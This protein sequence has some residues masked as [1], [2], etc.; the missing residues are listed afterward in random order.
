MIRIASARHFAVATVGFVT[1]LSLTTP[2]GATVRAGTLEC[3][4]SG[5]VG[6]VFVEKQEMRCT[7]RPAS[8][9]APE[10]YVGKIV[11]VGIALG[12]TAG[13][14]MVWGVL[15]AEHDIARGALA[16]TYAG[17]SANASIGIGGGANVL[18]GGTGRAF[19]LQPLSLEG[20]LGL[21]V[22]GGVTTVTLRPAP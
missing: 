2:A 8:G 18:I 6:L 11:E 9:K 19:V 4:I 14:V 5:G 10:S 22:A 7:Y 3:N 17:V 13:G 12:A 20:Q 16:G 15:A 21:N 1:A